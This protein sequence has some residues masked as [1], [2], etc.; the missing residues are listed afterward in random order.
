[1]ANDEKK[2]IVGLLL[3]MNVVPDESEE[4]SENSHD[5]KSFATEFLESDE[6]E[7]NLLDQ[8]QDDISSSE[9]QVNVS[10]SDKSEQESHASSSLPSKEDDQLVLN[11]MESDK[12]SK[13]ILAWHPRK[14]HVMATNHPLNWLLMTKTPT[15]ALQ[16]QSR[17]KR[18]ETFHCH[19]KQF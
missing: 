11:M 12:R 18:A 13:T 5:G 1:V 16:A 2:D 19:R 17:T 3:D 9:A 15:M 8:V 14:I 6:D 7:E 10:K 4:D